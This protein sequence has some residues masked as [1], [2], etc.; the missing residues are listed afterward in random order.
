MDGLADAF[1]KFLLKLQD[2]LF[3]RLIGR[4]FDADM[5]EEFT[6]SD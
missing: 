2:H 1:K 3:R 4:E 6:D 5:H